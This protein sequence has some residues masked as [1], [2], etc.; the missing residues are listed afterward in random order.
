MLLLASGLPEP[1]RSEASME[2]QNIGKCHAYLGAAVED[3]AIHRPRSGWAGTRVRCSDLVGLAC[4]AG[5]S[6]LD[7]DAVAAPARRYSVQEMLQKG[8]DDSRWVGNR[9]CSV[10]QLT[11]SS[12]LS[13]LYA[14][15]SVA[16]LTR[17]SAAG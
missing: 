14:Q 15:L 9:V 12:S 6:H 4:I 2:G 13:V 10:M 11:V 1:I 5:P 3:S 17:G 16:R 8:S 7:C